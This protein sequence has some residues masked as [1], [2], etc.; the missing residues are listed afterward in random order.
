VNLLQNPQPPLLRKR[1]GAN[2]RDWPFFH[3]SAQQPD[4]IGDSSITCLIRS[5][6]FEAVWCPLNQCKSVLDKSLFGDVN[7]LEHFK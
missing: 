7:A 4:F 2:G 6:H 3:A 1:S 5:Y